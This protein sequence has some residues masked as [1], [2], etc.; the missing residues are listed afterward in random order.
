MTITNTIYRT[1]LQY[2]SW[3]MDSFVIP[4]S[5]SI[6]ETYMK[7]KDYYIIQCQKEYNLVLHNLTWLSSARGLD[8]EYFSITSVIRKKCWPYLINSP[9]FYSYIINTHFIF[10][11]VYVWK[12]QSAYL[13]VYIYKHP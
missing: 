4:W 6:S 12:G 1:H 11:Y 7:I 10:K 9:D 2:R 8:L 13:Q 3:I 5:V